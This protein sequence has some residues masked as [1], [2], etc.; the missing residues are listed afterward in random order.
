VGTTGGTSVDGAGRSP[1]A[2]DLTVVEIGS[3][4]ANGSPGA[5]AGGLVTAEPGRPGEPTL[6][7][8]SRTHSIA[9]VQD[10]L[11]KIWGSISL[12]TSAAPGR[13][14]D[15]TPGGSSDERRVAARSSVMNLVV[16]AGRG[17]I[18]QRAAAVIQGLTGRHPSRTIIVTP[19]DP[20]GPPWLDAQVQAHC[21]LPTADS[22]ETCAELIYLT[23]GGESGQHLAGLIAPLLVHDLPVTVWWPNEPRLESRPTRDLLVMAD[24][25][26]VDGAGWSG[27]GLKRLAELARLPEMYGI[28]IADFALLRQARWREAI[29]SSFDLPRL[30]PFLATIRS[31]TVRYAAHDGTPGA[32]NVVKPLYHLAWLASR[33]G[34][35]VVEPLAAGEWAWSG[36]RG[37]LRAGRRR[38]ALALEPLESAHPGGT[39]LEVE[40]DA[41][42]G[43]HHLEVRVTGQSDGI[44]VATT[45][46]GGRMPDRHYLEPRRQEHELLAET[47]ED[48]AAHPITA[49]ALAMAAALVGQP[50]P[51]HHAGQRA[52]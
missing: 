14:L 27:D 37:V 41:A 30:L 12:A 11:E 51:G 36:Y 35:I 44:T 43:S 28:E 20:D 22:P 23:A 7:W 49:E 6:R 50:L 2:A 8:S 34:M 47:L 33:L 13:G 18:G 26:L 5:R 46:E 29:A 15:G 38:V 25:V 42:R 39:T 48:E 24:R 21:V 17:E 16:V 9:G 10:E 1:L 4:G 19:A 31:I 32:T 52:A 3:P 40:I 45:V